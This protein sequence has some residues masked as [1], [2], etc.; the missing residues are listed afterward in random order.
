MANDFKPLHFRIF[1]LVTKTRIIH[2]GD[3]LNIDRLHLD[4]YT[5]KK[6]QGTS[7][8]VEMYVPTNQARIIFAD[9]STCKLSVNG[10]GIY[11]EMWSGTL[12]NGKPQARIL[13][14]GATDANKPAFIEVM[15]CEGQRLRGGAIKPKKGASQTRVRIL[16]D[17]RTARTLSLSVLEHLQAWSTA[18]YHT[19]IAE[20][21]W[22]PD[23]GADQQPTPRAQASDKPPILANG[24]PVPDPDP[25][26]LPPMPAVLS[27]ALNKWDASP[28]QRGTIAYQI[29][30][31]LHE[32]FPPAAITEIV[33]K[34]SDTHADLLQIGDAIVKSAARHKHTPDGQIPGK[35]YTR[36][37]LINRLQ[38]T[39]Q[40]ADRLQL[41]DSQPDTP[42]WRWAWSPNQI[43]KFGQPLVQRINQAN[44][45]Q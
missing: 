23:P 19:R 35:S 26:N 27:T 10:D 8:H 12:R 7:A 17:W 25:T 42:L 20:A 14:I 11:T 3:A 34:A 28:S 44:Q 16:L 5:Y 21:T 22:T 6:G 37:H 32:K 30:R 29:R 13:R 36:P 2:V 18:T 31:A 40:E 9:L 43:I 39:I 41:P 1:S 45:K 38:Q 33:V 4:L 24:N 15:N